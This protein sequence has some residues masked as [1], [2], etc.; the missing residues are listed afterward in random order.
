MISIIAAVDRRMA[1]GYRN[2]LLFCTIKNQRGLAQ[3]EFLHDL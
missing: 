2:K 1:I 3:I